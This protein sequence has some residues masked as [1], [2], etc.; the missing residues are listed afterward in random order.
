MKSNKNRQLRNRTQ[1]NNKI[2]C[3]PSVKKNVINSS[4]CFT[5]DVLIKIKEAY[6]IN[7]PQSK[8]KNTNSRKIWW[9]LKKRLDCKKE[10]CWLEQ[11]NDSNLKTSIRRHI[12]A[13]KH[14]PEWNSNPDEWLSNYDIEDV[15]KQYELSNPEFKMI[16]PTSID[17]DTKLPENGGTCVLEDLCNFNLVN[18]IKTKKTKIGIV[19]NLDRHDQSGSHWVSLFIDINAKYII[20]FDSADNDIPPEIWKKNLTGKIIPLVNRIINQGNEIGI[21]LKFY[22]NSGNQHQQS[23]TECGMYS[24]FFIIT[25]LTGE[26]VFTKGKLSNKARRDL[27]LKRRIPDKTVFGHRKIYFND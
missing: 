21:K 22:N 11:I 18:F 25:M 16:G 15:A 8:I 13:P 26:T 1:K 3:S 20:Y 9:E 4:T 7:H 14:P 2:N 10:D 19:F 24:L 23:N 6:N 17:F 27:F 12:F 5:S